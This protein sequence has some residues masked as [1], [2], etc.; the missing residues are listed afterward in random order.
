MS[1]QNQA[2][3]AVIG[4]VVVAAGVMAGL[5]GYEKIGKARD[6]AKRK[7][8]YELRYDCENRLGDMIEFVQLAG[9]DKET[10]DWLFLQKR[11]GKTKFTFHEEG[12]TVLEKSIKDIQRDY[13][14]TR[15]VPDRNDVRRNIV[16]YCEIER[17]TI[18]E[19]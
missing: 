8:L 2:I 4:V 1:S 16:F 6:D 10:A 18:N 11:S 3:K 15:K 14:D 5:Y 19:S 13:A 7:S 9:T 17:Q 12:M